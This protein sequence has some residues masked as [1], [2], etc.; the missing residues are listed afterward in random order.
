[1]RDDRLRG[2]LTLLVCFWACVPD[3]HAGWE[4]TFDCTAPEAGAQESRHGRDRWRAWLHAYAC[5]HASR[6]A[7][8]ASDASG[9]AICS[10]PPYRADETYRFGDRVQ[11]GGQ[12][13]ECARSSDAAACAACSNEP[14]SS[15]SEVWRALGSCVTRDA[16]V[17]DDRAEV[18]GYYPSPRSYLLAAGSA[19][20]ARWRYTTTAPADDWTST[21]FDD[22]QWL[23]GESGFGFGA[24]PSS[25]GTRTLWPE[26]A[27]SLWLR[28]NLTLSAC[29]L[30]RAMLWARWDQA[31]TVYINGVEA[32]REVAAYGNY[33]YLGLS[34]AARAALREGENVIAVHVSGS[35]AARHFDLGV[36]RFGALASRPVAGSPRT[37]ALAVYGEAL[38]EFMIEHGIPAGVLAVMKRDQMVVAQ[39]FGWADKEFTRPLPHDAVLRLASNDK[40]FTLA[41]TRTLVDDATIDPV[42]GQQVTPDTQVFPLL[43]VHG[44]TPIPSVA[45]SPAIESVTVLH[46]MEHRA[47]LRELPWPEQFYAD[48]QRLPGSTSA[49]DNV[50]WVYSQA[51]Q[52]VPGSSQ[53]YSSSGYMVLRHFVASVHGDLLRYLRDVVLAP[54]GTRDVF[55]AHERLA[56]RSAREP[57]YAT[58]VAPYDRWIYLEDY[59]ALASS[60]EALARLLRG[61]HLGFGTRLIDPS[62]GAWSA[63]LDNGGG[64]FIGGYEGTWSMAL[65]RRWDEVNIAVIFN[66]GGEYSALN[67]QLNAITDGI[68]EAEWTDAIR[69]Q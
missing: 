59:T 1:M 25:D 49:I 14:P 55:I 60:A 30:P 58:F 50:R 51:P 7:G 10:V 3:E 28:A 8:S 46:L 32:V 66:I 56:S 18:D 5:R 38:R 35:Q 20:G 69:A 67:E 63:G 4:H 26:D 45:P 27:A 52:F 41:A 13:Y 22:A 43:R 44:L 29:D 36:T 17:S 6:D 64:V 11:S 65:Q 19:G 54:V 12:I 61:Y 53:V 23:E 31:L 34:S 47:G 57:W 16:G 68:S 37:P 9:S 48:L 2:L 62:T 39:G 21:S 40:L 24:P 33:R 15:G 42:S